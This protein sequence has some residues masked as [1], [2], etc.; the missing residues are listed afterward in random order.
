MLLQKSCHDMDILQWLIGKQCK[1][2]QSFGSTKFFNEANA[3]AGSPDYCIQGC[4]VGDTCP[5][6][7]VKLY[8]DDKD[9]KWFRTTCT[10]LADPTDEDVKN[11]LC[12]NVERL[13]GKDF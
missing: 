11:I 7:S 12:D 1:K 8:L 3:P 10:R 6:N 5:Y 13:F 2:V 9:N 4:P